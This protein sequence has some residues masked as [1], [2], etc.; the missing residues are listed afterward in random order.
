MFARACLGLLAVMI[1]WT[2]LFVNLGLVIWMAVTGKHMPALTAV[3]FLLLAT[4][5]ACSAFGAHLLRSS[6]ASAAPPAPH[7]AC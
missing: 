3:I 7:E 1:T 5:I 6:E 2:A 4:T